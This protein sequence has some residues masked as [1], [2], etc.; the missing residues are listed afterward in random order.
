MKKFVLASTLLLYIIGVDAQS[1]M[2]GQIAVKDLNVARNEGNLF[3]TMDLDLTS[4]DLKSNH[5]IVLTP[6]L[7]ALDD[8]LKLPQV[9][10][11]GRNRYYSYIR[12]A[13]KLNNR[14]LYRVGKTGEVH[15]QAT[16]P[17]EEWMET[18]E[19]ILQQDSCGCQDKILMDNSELLTAIDFAPKV[20]KPV[21]A[22]LPPAAEAVRMREISGQA[23]IDFPV[24][25]TEIY[26]DYRNNPAELQKII[27]TIDAVKDDPD[28]K[29]TKVH[30]KGYAS[31]ESPY[32]NNTRLAKGRT[33]T[34]KKYV[35]NLYHFHESVITTDF[36]P[37]DWA[38]LRAYVEK[39]Q[40]LQH[41]ENILAII[42]SDEKDMDRKE[43]RIKS[44]YPEDYQFLLKNCYPALRHSDYKVE[45]IVRSFTDV[46]EAKK[47]MKTAPGKLSQQE[48]YLIAQS[49][50]PGSEDYNE[51]FELMVR[52]FPD[53]ETANLNAANVAMG[54]GDLAAAKKYLAKVGDT[55]EA[56]HARGVLFG[57]EGDYDNA[58][59]YLQKA[60]ASGIRQ[61]AENLKQIEELEKHKQ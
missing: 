57:L 42:D 48:L 60:S 7:V 4:L 61:A 27:A 19:L 47:V 12:N 23:Y 5:E 38:G 50:E 51:T 55:P 22:Y 59:T 39:S 29:I 9:L 40:N 52:L 1:V 24:S 36:E 11:A 8:T 3:V 32:S 53:D 30:I 20:F 45:Y 33:A 31:P 26:E 46:E 56:N 16:T 37:E 58:R 2:N 14:E 44:N 10:V 21:F 34:L 43:A 17:F 13:E 18:S 6:T 15:Y 25:R 41:K 54:K 28:T 49:Y 35:Q